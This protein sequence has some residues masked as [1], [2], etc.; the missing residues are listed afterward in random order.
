VQKASLK[1]APDQRRRLLV[2]R[3]LADDDYARHWAN[4]WSD[5]LLANAG[6]PDARAGFHGWLAKHFARNGSHKELAEQLITAKG[7]THD[8][9]AGHFLAV[10]R[11]AAIP[12]KDQNK[13]G[14][15]DMIPATGKIFQ[16]LQAR[17]LDCV[18]CHDHPDNDDVRQDHFWGMNACFRQLRFTPKPVDKKKDTLELDDDPSLNKSGLL[19]F[20]RRNGVWFATDPSFYGAKMKRKMKQTRREFL[21]EHFVKH[22]DFARGYVNFMW[23]QL[24]GHGLTQS[25]EYDD[26]GEHNRLVHPKIMDRLA[27]DFVTSGHDPKAFLRWICN[28]DAYSLKSVAN[29][30]NAGSDK[31][32]CFSRAKSRPL[33]RRQLAE[34]I[35]VALT[36]DDYLKRRDDLREEMLREIPPASPPEVQECELVP[37]NFEGDLS[38]RRALWIMN[39]SVLERELVDP[40]GTVAKALKVHG[41]SEKGLPG[42]ITDL[43]VITL[44][45]APTPQDLK[46]LTDPQ[47]YGSRFKGQPI[48]PTFWTQYAQDIF[49]ALLNSNEFAL[50]H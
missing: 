9:P 50:N 8:N 29:K 20:E 7:T 33:S 19:G 5:W 44:C 24:F 36:T 26:M 14:Q 46:H 32:V 2:D 16:I 34:S 22:P 27:A 10:H 12:L 39:S 30:T 3:L 28:S 18:H 37:L 25:A 15:Y 31:A 23:A 13:L 45:R 35:I 47:F 49:W 41:A 38:I 48:P 42:V 6:E 1:D 21:A 40:R 43:Y 11:G 4:V 17:R